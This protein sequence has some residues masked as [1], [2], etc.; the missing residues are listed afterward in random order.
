M[1]GLT[2]SLPGGRSLPTKNPVAYAAQSSPT[3]CVMAASQCDDSCD[4][5]EFCDATCRHAVCAVDRV[6]PWARKSDK[7][8]GLPSE[9]IDDE[10]MELAEVGVLVD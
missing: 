7:R 10:E 6:G 5:R 9:K 3:G 4:A 8:Q 2:T 1:Q